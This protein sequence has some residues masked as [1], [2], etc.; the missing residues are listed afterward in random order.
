MSE[1]LTG[2][3]IPEPGTP[4]EPDLTSK[5]ASRTWFH[6]VSIAATRNSQS[7]YEWRRVA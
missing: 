5:G 4:Y 7:A 1:N 6:E 3:K 2:C